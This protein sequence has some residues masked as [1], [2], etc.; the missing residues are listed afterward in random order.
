MVIEILSARVLYLRKSKK[1][2]QTELADAV[3]VSQ[4]CIKDLETQYRFS[5]PDT[6]LAIANYFNVSLD[7]L[8][9]RTNNPTYQPD[10]ESATL[11]PAI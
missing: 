3:G 6:I 2:T 1:I 8:Y 9:G 5:K 7:Y 11:E 10:E 4:S